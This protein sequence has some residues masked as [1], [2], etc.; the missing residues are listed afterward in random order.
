M[1]SMSLTSSTTTA[2]VPTTTPAPS[3]AVFSLNDPSSWDVGSMGMGAAG[4]FIIF[5]LFV[6]LWCCLSGK[7]RKYCCSGWGTSRESVPAN[8]ESENQ[9]SMF[10]D[11][12]LMDSLKMSASIIQ[13]KQNQ[14]RANDYDERQGLL[15]GRQHASSRNNHY[16]I[17]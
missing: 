17:L 14:R 12:S 11:T 2:A 13:A 9:R 15:L 3:K 8:P 6:A 16:D 7:Y 1:S 4:L 5:A 10:H